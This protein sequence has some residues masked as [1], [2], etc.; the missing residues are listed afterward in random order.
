MRAL[1]WAAHD[2]LRATAANSNNINIST[3]KHEPEP[4]SISRRLCRYIIMAEDLTKLSNEELK[5]LC[6]HTK[7][8]ARY[9][10]IINQSDEVKKLENER[11]VLL[12]LVRSLSEFNLGRKDDYEEGRSHLLT[13]VA[14]S[15]KLKEQIQEKATTL[16]DISKKTSLEST[17]AV[18]LGATASSEEESENIAK[19]FL[20]CKIDFENFVSQYLEKRKLAHLRRIKADR[21][22]QET[23]ESWT[24]IRTQSFGALS[25]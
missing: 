14:E 11:E 6:D 1:R 21:L 23:N 3:Q 18:V 19:S 25:Q 8:E 16:L 12:A 20:D 17:L 2:S 4:S 13:L 10:E 24:G 15:N 5:E 9:D 22:R 7:S